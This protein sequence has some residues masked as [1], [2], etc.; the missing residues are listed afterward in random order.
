MSPNDRLLALFWRLNAAASVFWLAGA[1]LNSV[2][3]LQMMAG[4]VFVALALIPVYVAASVVEQ[5]RSSTAARG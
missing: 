2:W 1:A 3:L 4:C 5:T